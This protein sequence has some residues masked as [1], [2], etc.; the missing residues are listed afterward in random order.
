MR[1]RGARYGLRARAICQA[2]SDREVTDWVGTVERLWSNNEGR[3]VLSVRVSDILSVETMNNAFSD[4]DYNTLIP[5]GSK[6]QQEAMALHQ[7]ERVTFSGNFVP[8]KD[9]CIKENSLTVSGDMTE[10]AFLF[11]FSAIRP[12]E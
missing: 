2:L 3:G 12:A 4:I 6:V 5:V 7:G 11:R 10:P 8:D 9:D 1:W